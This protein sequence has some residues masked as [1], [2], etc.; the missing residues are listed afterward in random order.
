MSV[1]GDDSLHV[2]GFV[3]NWN[4]KEMFFAEQLRELL[5]VHVIGRLRP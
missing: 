2:A 4:R 5:L 1:G 3:H